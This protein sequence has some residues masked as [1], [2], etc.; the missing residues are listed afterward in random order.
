MVF[1]NRAM[2]NIRLGNYAQAEED[3]SRA[4]D[5][6]PEYIKAVSRRGMARHKQGKYRGAVADFTRA[7]ELEP[8]NKHVSQLLARSQ[9]Q[10][11]E[12][13]GLSLDGSAVDI[14]TL[15]SA[16]ENNASCKYV[17]KSKIEEIPLSS[18]E[19]RMRKLIIQGDDSDSDSD[20]DDVPNISEENDGHMRR[21]K[22]M[23]VDDEEEEEEEEDDDD[24]DTN[25]DAS[26]VLV[27]SEEAKDITEENNTFAGLT[28]S[29]LK[30]RGSV[31]FKAGEVGEALTCFEMA[32]QR[33]DENAESRQRCSLYNNCALCYLQMKNYEGV[34]REASAAI[35]A[36]SSG[37][38][39]IVLKALLRRGTAYEVLGKQQLA[40]DD[41]C[42]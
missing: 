11:E 1:A 38:D 18:S 39:G 31:H 22:I 35:D 40:L 28:S 2:A 20:E 8:K 3:C 25:S 7:L 36:A 5:L 37:D 21:L 41:M 13:G 12:V 19:P 24:D 6:S 27:K 29:V 26:Y 10:Y 30:D 4:I 23:Q 9:Q 14:P 32:L 17:K 34:V 33:L 42:R 15:K 16:K